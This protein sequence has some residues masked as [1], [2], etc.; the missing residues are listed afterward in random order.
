LELFFHVRLQLFQILVDFNSLGHF[1]DLLLHLQ[2][3]E[4]LLLGLDKPSDAVLLPCVDLIGA[5]LHFLHLCHGI[6]A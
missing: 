2:F 3:V 6:I 5:I 4:L 1:L